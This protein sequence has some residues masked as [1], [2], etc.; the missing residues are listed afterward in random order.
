ML[1]LVFDHHGH[2]HGVTRPLE[3]RMIVE[4]SRSPGDNLRWPKRL[5]TKKEELLKVFHPIEKKQVYIY[6]E[7]K[8]R[9]CC[10]VIFSVFWEVSM[11]ASFWGVCQ[12][13]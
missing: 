6:E 12:S 7:I 3:A 5:V 13:I 8:K 10:T 4:Q 11:R 2:S 9:M 1:G